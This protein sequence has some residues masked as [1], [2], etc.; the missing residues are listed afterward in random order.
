M[1]RRVCGQWRQQATRSQGNPQDRPGIQVYG[2]YSGA[3]GG[4]QVF[5]AKGIY[6]PWALS[7]IAIVLT[8]PLSM[9]DAS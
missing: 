1:A 3:G 6:L 9:T 5:P 7:G 4:Y 2:L 8:G